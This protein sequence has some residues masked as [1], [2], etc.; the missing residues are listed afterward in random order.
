[1]IDPGE[2]KPGGGN[3]DPPAIGPYRGKPGEIIDPTKVDLCRGGRSLE[4]KPGEIRV[5]R[6]GLVQ[7]THG[8]SFET[9]PARLERFGVQVV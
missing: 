4:V 2:S 1:V 6:D 9:D 3:S 7:P 5:G 8:L